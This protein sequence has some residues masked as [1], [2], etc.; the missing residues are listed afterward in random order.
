MT[1]EKKDSKKGE[2]R[3][4]KEQA[5]IS[6]MEQIQQK[7]GEGAIMKFGDTRKVD[8]DSVSTSCL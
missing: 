4:A 7:Y 3:S 1:T 2:S 5:A 8:V 6:A